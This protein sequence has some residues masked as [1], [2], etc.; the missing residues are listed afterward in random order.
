MGWIVIRA[1]IFIESLK[2]RRAIRRLTTNSK[3]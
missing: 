2:R 1:I 3:L